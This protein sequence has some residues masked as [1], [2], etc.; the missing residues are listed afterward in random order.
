MYL[1]VLKATRFEQWKLALSSPFAG[2]P[3]IVS[4]E[5]SDQPRFMIHA[6]D[7]I[8]FDFPF[9]GRPPALAEYRRT[10]RQTWFEDSLLSPRRQRRGAVRQR[11][12]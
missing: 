12:R 11:R 8:Y 9:S 6:G 1:S 10:Y 5:Q 2:L 7:Q 3:K 4:T